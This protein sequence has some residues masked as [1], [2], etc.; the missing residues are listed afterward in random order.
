[1]DTRLLP[2]E[3]GIS[4]EV[5]DHKKYIRDTYDWYPEW[6]NSTIT[7]KVGS[8]EIHDYFLTNSTYRNRVVFLYDQIYNYYVRSLA[9]LIKSLKMMKE[10]IG[11]IL[12]K[13][14]D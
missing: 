6:I 8:K 5:V 2:L 14:N 13:G 7:Q 9:A 10:A 3:N 4:N 11:E 12:K 1:M